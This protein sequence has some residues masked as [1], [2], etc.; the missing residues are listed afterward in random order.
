MILIKNEEFTE[1]EQN[2]PNFIQL[3]NKD[4]NSDIEI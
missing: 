3:D 1:E 4:E 2:V